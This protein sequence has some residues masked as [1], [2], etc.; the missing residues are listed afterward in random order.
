[1]P[2][3]PPELVSLPAVVADER[4]QV[5]IGKDDLGVLLLKVE[6]EGITIFTASVAP[7]NRVHVVFIASTQAGD[8]ATS[9]PR[10]L[11]DTENAQE[12]KTLEREHP[13][14]T[15][16]GVPI[17]GA[18]YNKEKRTYSL[19]IAHHPNA[20]NRKEAV[21]YNIVA[22]GEKAEELYKAYVT[23]SRTPV[24]VTGNDASFTLARKGKPDKRVYKVQADSIEKIKGRW[25]SPKIL[26][27]KVK[28]ASE[29]SL[30]AY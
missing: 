20:E 5:R 13:L 2:A 12:Q 18:R 22:E 8:K 6:S 21:Y 14:I 29:P 27:E 24:R 23:D 15:I 25:D 28:L 4:H 30:P 16:E 10:P 3:S 1:M 7:D 19:T 9:T 17:R 26:P 11:L